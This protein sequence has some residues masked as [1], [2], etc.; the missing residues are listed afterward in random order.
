MVRLSPGDIAHPYI[1]TGQRFLILGTTGAGGKACY[2]AVQ[3]QPDGAIN[4][5]K[6]WTPLVGI[7]VKTV[8]PR[9]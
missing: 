5:S 7:M 1:N 3:L 2:V 9:P 6:I 4:T 8:N